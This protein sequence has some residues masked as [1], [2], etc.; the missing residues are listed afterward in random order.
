MNMN[1]HTVESVMQEMQGTLSVPEL[2][3]LLECQF[4]DCI[5]LRIPV[6]SLLTCTEWFQDALKNGGNGYYES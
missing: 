3:Y 6:C 5:V 2:Q 1:T 4:I